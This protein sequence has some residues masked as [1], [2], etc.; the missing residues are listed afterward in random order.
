M[1]SQTATP[2]R[3]EIRSETANRRHS[4]LMRASSNG[5]LCRRRRS[6]PSKP[7]VVSAKLKGVPKTHSQDSH[8]ASRSNVAGI[9][10]LLSGSRARAAVEDDVPAGGISGRIASGSIASAP[11]VES[12]TCATLGAAGASCDPTIR[13]IAAEATLKSSR[14]PRATR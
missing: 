12:A 8:A 4:P 9:G 1:R 3:R 6:A 14:L 13:A 2:I 11:P 7:A 10:S 5:R